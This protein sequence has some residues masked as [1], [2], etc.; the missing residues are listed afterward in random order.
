[1]A[2]NPISTITDQ[3]PPPFDLN[4]SDDALVTFGAPVGVGALS[5]SDLGYM[6]INNL[7]IGEDT[8][9]LKGK[10][11]GLFIQYTATGVQHF[12]PSGAPTTA[13]Y[14]SLQF[15]LMGYKGDAVFGHAADGTP[16]VT[17]ATHLTE[18]A[19]GQLITGELGFNPTGGITGD[20]NASYQIDGHVAGT[21][22]ISVQ[23]AA[24]D[25]G[26]NATGFT[27]SG[28]TLHATFVPLSVG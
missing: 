12:S 25:I 26:P 20:V 5:F 13:D 8:Q 17:G 14:T 15:E 4:M 22:D 10:L 1:M 18:L 7:T 2:Q 21:L 16:T 27:L 19:Q 28:G 24:A 6:P 11:D 23:H 9:Q 3:N